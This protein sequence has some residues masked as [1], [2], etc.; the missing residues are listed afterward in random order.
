MLTMGTISTT[1]GM[2]GVRTFFKGTWERIGSFLVI[3]HNKI[4]F[5]YDFKHFN[6]VNAT[7]I[8]DV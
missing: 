1:G 4:R 7:F 5:V 6:I 3:I 8:L 2:I